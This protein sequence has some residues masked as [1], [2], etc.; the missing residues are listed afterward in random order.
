M[1]RRGGLRGPSRG[2][3]AWTAYIEDRVDW[4]T[5][6]R[7]RWREAGSPGRRARW[8]YVL[9]SGGTLLAADMLRHVVG[10]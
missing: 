10:G 5:Q 9:C 3:I 2:V 1:R 4:L 6:A 8:P 7:K